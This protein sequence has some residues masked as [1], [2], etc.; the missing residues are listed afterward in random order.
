MTDPTDGRIEFGNRY[1]NFFY[2]G[3]L[4]PHAFNE[5]PGNVLEQTGS[6]T[7]NFDGNPVQLFVVDG[8]PQPVTFCG[9]VK[10]SMDRDIQRVFVSYFL[11]FVVEAMVGK[12]F[13]SF[14]RYGSQG[15]VC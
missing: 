8:S 2:M 9:G 12:K 11:L 4:L 15:F 13:Q 10:V 6:L 3:I 7:H 5:A 14:E 1:V